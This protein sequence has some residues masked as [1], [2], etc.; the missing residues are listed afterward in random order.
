MRIGYNASPMLLTVLKAKLHH[1]RITHTELEYEGSC[2]IDS[3]LLEMV[4]IHP[5][6]QIDI[7]NLDNGERFTTY[8]IEAPPG[9][10][11]VSLRGA[12][13][14]KGKPS[15]RVIIC[16]YAQLESNL[17]SGHQPTVCVLNENNELKHESKI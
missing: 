5:F 12:A 16:A 3:A 13:A 1:A 9:S 8:A 15:E 10:G 14:H 11:M 6:E 4:G 2:A 7:Y 17:I